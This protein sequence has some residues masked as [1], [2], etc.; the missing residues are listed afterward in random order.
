MS[1]NFDFAYVWA[2]SKRCVRWSG[3]DAKTL[4]SRIPDDFKP[5][6]EEFIR[7]SEPGHI[8]TV[9]PSGDLTDQPIIVRIR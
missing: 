2:D 7:L 4:L 9:P 6:V 1:Y 5:E 3:Q 8:L